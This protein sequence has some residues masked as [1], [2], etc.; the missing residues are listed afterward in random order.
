MYVAHQSQSYYSQIAH[1]SLSESLTIRILFYESG[2]LSINKNH[3]IQLSLFR[4][5]I[6]S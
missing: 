2:N 4:K 6:Q 3:L 1:K 5:Y